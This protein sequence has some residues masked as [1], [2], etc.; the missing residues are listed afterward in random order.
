MRTPALVLLAAIVVALAACSAPSPSEVA[1][2]SAD[3]SPRVIAVTMTDA[4]RFEPD[5][6]AV[7]PG[8]TIRFEVANAGQIRHE[9]YIGD[10]D[11]QAAHEA[12]MIEMGGMAHDEPNGISVEP[13]G[14]KVLDYTF[15]APGTLLIGCHEPGHYDAGMMATVEV[16]D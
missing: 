13:G 10:A 16:G 7:S 4:L 8:E 3:E 11:D 2:P 12:E 14:S 15:D 5:A 1:S 9:F 6:F